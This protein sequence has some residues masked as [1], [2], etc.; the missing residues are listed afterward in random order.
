MYE[1]FQYVEFCGR[2]RNK[3]RVAES[4]FYSVSVNF[5]NYGYYLHIQRRSAAKGTWWWLFR[6]YHV[7]TC[8]GALVFNYETSRGMAEVRRWRWS[9]KAVACWMLF[10]GPYVPAT[11]LFSRWWC[12]G[13]SCCQKSQLRAFI[14]RRGG[15]GSPVA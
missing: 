8:H 1:Y 13:M 4:R 2:F 7:I 15:G 6:E 5:L 11:P 14:P 3:D 9:G 12:V 10:S